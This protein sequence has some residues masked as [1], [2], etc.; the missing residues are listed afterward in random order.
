MSCQVPWKIEYSLNKTLSSSSPD[1]IVIFLLAPRLSGAYE[2][3]KK[4]KTHRRIFFSSSF[5]SGWY[6]FDVRWRDFNELVVTSRTEAIA[7]NVG[8][9]KIEKK[10]RSIIPE[11]IRLSLSRWWHVSAVF[12]RLKPGVLYFHTFS[13]FDARREMNCWRETKGQVDARSPPDERKLWP[14]QP[15]A[16]WFESQVSIPTFYIDLKSMKY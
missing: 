4:K 16:Q 13:V 15:M 11:S 3:E 5:R 2:N 9:R 7:R 8:R 10:S 6:L 12:V 1:G 14:N